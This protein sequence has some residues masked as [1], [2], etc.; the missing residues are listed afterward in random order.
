MPSLLTTLIIFVHFASNRAVRAT[1]HQ[2]STIFLLA[3]SFVES[4]TGTSSAID[5]YRSNGV[6]RIQTSAYCA[7][8]V[9]NDYSLFSSIAFV[10]AWIS[11][12][13]HLLIFHRNL[14]GD[15][16]TWK[17]WFTHVAPWIICP[18]FPIL[19]YT[20]V[21]AISPMCTT[22]WYFD[23]IL[24]GQACYLT[25]SWASIDIFLN[26]VATISV[27][28]IAN[29]TLIL[30][31]IHQRRTVRGT[32]Q[33]DWRKQRKMVL[34]LSAFSTLYLSVWLP[35]S[36]IQLIQLYADPTF[37]AAQVD[38]FNFL[39]YVGILLLPGVCI[40]SIPQLSQRIRNL[41]RRRHQRAI[42]PL[43]QTQRKTRNADEGLEIAAVTTKV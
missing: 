24:C 43:A 36:S 39:A 18:M 42:A 25:T 10:M 41:F 32:T 8:W 40:T 9:V 6:V 11:I 1:D 4:L 13:R 31:V 20:V 33:V 19:F 37:L 23:T 7:W 5:F 17:R 12:E 2:H 27:I 38:T 34:Q 35:L 15:I 29:L 22:T 3:I 30:R 21:I 26:V 14:L 16:G 28:L